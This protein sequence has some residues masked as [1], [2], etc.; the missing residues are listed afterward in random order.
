MRH[1]LRQPNTIWDRWSRV[2][3]KCMRQDAPADVGADVLHVVL[4]CQLVQGLC[5]ILAS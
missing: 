3:R 5:I 1:F 4:V 2:L